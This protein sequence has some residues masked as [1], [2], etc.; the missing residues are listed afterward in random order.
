MKSIKL[1]TQIDEK[2]LKDLESYVNETGRTMSNVVNEAITEHLRR[3]QL[4]PAFRDAAN[5]VLDENVDLLTRLAT[6]K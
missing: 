2:L 6:Q 1:V 4:R 3:H 5:E